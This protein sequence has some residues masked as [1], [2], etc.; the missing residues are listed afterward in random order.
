MNFQ[1]S[2]FVRVEDAE[3]RKNL[4]AW[5]SH[6]G[7]NINDWYWNEYIRVIR[8]WTTPKGINK[9]VGYPWKQVRKADIDCGEN[10]EMFKAL[11]AMNDENMLYQ[12]VIDDGGNWGFCTQDDKQGRGIF[13][14]R[15][16]FNIR[17]YRKA[18]AEEIVAHFKNSK[19]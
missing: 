1:T 12:H 2:C 11:A 6:I 5:L 16:T 3:K 13:L 14:R 4:F 18:T 17:K 7:Y 15:T 9:A 10:I 8:C 19:Q